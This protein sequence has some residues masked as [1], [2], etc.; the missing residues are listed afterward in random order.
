MRTFPVGWMRREIRARLGT[1]PAADPANA[2]LFRAAAEQI[3]F[4]FA[5]TLRQCEQ[6]ELLL[7]FPAAPFIFPLTAEDPRQF[8]DY[9]EPWPAHDVVLGGAVPVRLRS[10]K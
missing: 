5:A 10:G 3:I 2:P 8:L 1:A 4:T 7:A 9:A 6:T